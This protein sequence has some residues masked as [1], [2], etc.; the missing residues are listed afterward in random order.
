MKALALIL[1]LGPVLAQAQGLT[2]AEEIGYE[3]WRAM[4]AGKTVVYQIDGK[5]FGFEHYHDGQKV[6]IQLADG[7]CLEGS[8]FMNKS[9]FCFDWQNGPLN[10]FHHKRLGDTIFVVGLDGNGAE[11]A[12][13]QRVSRIDSTPLACGPALLSAFIPG[14]RP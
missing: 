10:C 9:A 13:V 6:T 2:G 8:W 1:A 7:T 3:E 4:T 5:T 14:A 12:D 11:T